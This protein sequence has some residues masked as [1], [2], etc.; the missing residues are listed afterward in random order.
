MPDM[1]IIMQMANFLHRRVAHNHNSSRWSAKEEQAALRLLRRKKGDAVFLW[2]DVQKQF[3]K[4]TVPGIKSKFRLLRIEHDLFGLSYLPEK[5]NFLRNVA[6]KARP[7]AVFDAY[8]GSGVQTFLWAEEGAKVVYA[9]EIS[10]PKQKQFVARAKK[11]AYKE[12]KSRLPGWLLFCRKG[13][14]N[15][16]WKG[17][18]LRAAINLS[19]AQN[20]ADLLDL[21][22]CGTTLPDLPM[23]LR[24][25]KPRHLA[26]SYGEFHSY[27]FAREDVLRRVLCHRSINSSRMPEGVDGL[28]EQLHES[29]LVYGLRAGNKIGDA[30]WLKLVKGGSVWLGE[31]NKGILRRHYKVGK[32]PATADCLNLLAKARA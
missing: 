27:R 10:A 24:L 26:I 3:P 18:A 28:A 14:K 30:F 6:K 12:Q 19:A 4:R 29:T 1:Y 9:A 20:G 5:H 32:P 2:T 16:F 13:K 7:G 21:D 25:L 23:F 15:Y 22:T 11:E 31:K 17:S 8:A